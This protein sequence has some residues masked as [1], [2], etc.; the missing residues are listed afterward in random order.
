VTCTN[1]FVYYANET[2]DLLDYQINTMVSLTP[3]SIFSRGLLVG[4]SAVSAL[5]C[6]ADRKSGRNAGRKSGNAG[7]GAAGAAKLGWNY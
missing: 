2:R 3:P 4:A 6:S 5:F 7:T 1:N